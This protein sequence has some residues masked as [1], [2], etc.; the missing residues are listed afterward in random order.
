MEKNFEKKFQKKQFEKKK[1]FSQGQGLSQKFSKSKSRSKVKG[2]PKVFCLFFYDIIMCTVL[3]AYTTPID[4]VIHWI[5]AV[6][7]L[8]LIKYTSKHFPV[9]VPNCLALIHEFT[10][11]NSWRYCLTNLN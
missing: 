10:S 6:S 2:Q 4:R 1:Y 3:S 9:F 5:D 11:L 8:I 7:N